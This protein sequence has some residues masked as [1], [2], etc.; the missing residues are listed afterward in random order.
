MARVTPKYT[1]PKTA[2]ATVLIG[3]GFTV[4]HW[5]EFQALMRRMGIPPELLTKGI[6]IHVHEGDSVA[7]C[8]RYLATDSPPPPADMGKGTAEDSL[9]LEA[10]TILSS[11]HFTHCGLEV[12]E[13]VYDWEPGVV[14]VIW[15]L[16]PF[17][18]TVVDGKKNPYFFV[19]VTLVPGTCGGIDVARELAQKKFEEHH[20]PLTEFSA[21]N[22][23]LQVVRH[24]PEHGV[25]DSM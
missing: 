7:V 1:P 18:K 8:H 22:P 5:P 10:T 19:D 16:H 20:F 21:D 24:H 12:E 3:D 4:F 13:R 2:I 9:R 17:N 14:R 6:D 23:T 15:S 25:I 11:R